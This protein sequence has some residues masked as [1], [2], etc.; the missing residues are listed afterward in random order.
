MALPTVPDSLTLNIHLI[1]LGTERNLFDTPTSVLI[2]HVARSAL[3]ASMGAGTFKTVGQKVLA[4]VTVTVVYG[5][6][7]FEEVTLLA[8]AV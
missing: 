5:V 6:T 8:M 4:G 1:I 3:F 7:L 2:E